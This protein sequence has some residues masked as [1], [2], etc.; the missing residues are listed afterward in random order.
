MCVTPRVACFAEEASVLLEK[1]G[2]HD[3]RRCCWAVY[4]A[5]LPAERRQL[6]EATGY[7]NERAFDDGFEVID[8]A[9]QD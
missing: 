7:V 3:P 2:H 1:T 8:A 4:A 9:V 6:A 5:C